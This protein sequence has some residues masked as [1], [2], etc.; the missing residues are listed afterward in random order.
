MATVTATATSGGYRA[1]MGN[2]WR[3]SFTIAMTGTYTTSGDTM[4]LAGISPIGD[5]RPPLSVDV[6]GKNGFIYRYIGGTTSANGKV[7]IF[8]NSAG[9]GDSP[10]TEHSNAALVAGVTS[11]TI[12]CVAF[13]GK[14]T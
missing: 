13:W 7:M 4:S 8:T 11:D 3:T 9:G 1:K 12:K 2:V 10:L 5:G 6:Q 14:E